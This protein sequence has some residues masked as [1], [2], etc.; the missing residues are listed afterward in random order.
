MMTM[1]APHFLG[2][3]KNPDYTIVMN[4]I[5]SVFFNMIIRFFVLPL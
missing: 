3:A 2:N 5:S 4:H 1:I